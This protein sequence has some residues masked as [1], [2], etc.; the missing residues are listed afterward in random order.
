MIKTIA[1]FN[2][3]KKK[4]TVSKKGVSYLQLPWIDN[5]FLKFQKLV[6]P[7]VSNCYYAMEL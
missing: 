2:T 1:K 7:T 6:K 3:L 5:I 4:G